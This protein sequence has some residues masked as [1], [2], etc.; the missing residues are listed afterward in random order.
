MFEFK[1]AVYV[2]R[3]KNVLYRH[4]E[5]RNPCDCCGAGWGEWRHQTSGA[6]EGLIANKGIFVWPCKMNIDPVFGTA[7]DVTLGGETLTVSLIEDPEFPNT[8]QCDKPPVVPKSRVTNTILGVHFEYCNNVLEGHPGSYT[9]ERYYGYPKENKLQ[10]F[11]T[12]I[13]LLNKN[14]HLM[15]ILTDKQI[16]QFEKCIKDYPDIVRIQY[17]KK[18]VNRSYSPENNPRLT[19]LFLTLKD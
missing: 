1:Y 17:P 4:P 11:N 16:P 5:D 13:S 6:V 14:T 9:F 7:W 12:V 19:V 3:D 10:G 15:F 2:A 8:M 18:I